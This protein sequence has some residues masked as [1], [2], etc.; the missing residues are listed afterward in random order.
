MKWF[1]AI[2]GVVLAS[3]LTAGAL[4]VC[5]ETAAT[6]RAVRQTVQA[7]P[8]LVDAQ[9]TALRREAAAQISAARRDLNRQIGAA[10][11]DLTW[12]IEATRFDAVEQL[13]GMRRDLQPVLTQASD[14]LKETSGSVAGLRADIQPTIAGANLLMDRHAL[15]A[16][17]LGAV[18]AVKTTAGQTTVAMRTFNAGFP[19]MV[20]NINAGTQ[21]GVT[22]MQHI[23]RWTRPDP[24]FI[25]GLKMAA[26]GIGG[27]LGAYWN[28]RSKGQTK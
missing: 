5:I 18:A 12:Q 4:S 9:A 2:V 6:L 11:R 13:D 1:L 19:Q 28:N 14:S 7:V 26:P 17:L 23:E 20:S 22:T 10:R 15:P 24:W 21:V 16:Q 27:F 3:L 8:L 25:Q